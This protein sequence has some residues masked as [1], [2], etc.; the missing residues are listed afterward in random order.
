MDAKSDS[1]NYK[2]NDMKLTIEQISSAGTLPGPA[3]IFQIQGDINIFSAK[4]LKDAFNESIENEVYI[5]LIDLSGVRVMDSSGIATF[6][7]THS[8][9]NK[10]PNA[11]IILYSITPE[12][13]KMLELTRLK[14]LL[15]TASNFAEAIRLFS[16]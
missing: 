6:I 15:R 2:T 4:K 3:V 16:A 9:L 14:S 1:I 7:A 11:G 5:L 12:I 13:E 10:M 8:R